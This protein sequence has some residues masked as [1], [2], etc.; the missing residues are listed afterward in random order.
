MLL[1][2]NADRTLAQLAADAALIES[3]GR[4]RD[5]PWRRRESMRTTASTDQQFAASPVSRTAT[6]TKTCE[7]L[8]RLMRIAIVGDPETLHE[9]LTD[10]AHGWSPTLVFSS[11]AEAEAALADREHPLSVLEFGIDRLC[12]SDTLVFAEWNL[13]ASLQAPLLIG[14][15]ILVEAED[16]NVSLVG[17]TVA[18][19]CG[20]LLS[21]VHTYFDDASLIEQVILDP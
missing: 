8:T 16:G 12:W 15:D 1:L 7:D 13:R 10:D 11:R 3:V 14:D 18:V 6:E 5:R 9:A 21:A 4:V 20:P 19:R 17:A 2:F